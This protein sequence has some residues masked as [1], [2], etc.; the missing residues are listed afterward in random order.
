M[1]M[2]DTTMV[3]CIRCC[4]EKEQ[5]G[6]IKN[7]RA[8]SGYSTLCKECSN[9]ERRLYLD[10]RREL[11][12]EKN[13]RKYYENHEKNRKIKTERS[14]RFRQEN[15]EEYKKIQFEWRLKNPEKVRLSA[16]LS[17]KKKEFKEKRN[18]RLRENKKEVDLPKIRARKILQTAVRIGHLDRPNK[19][20]KCMK[21]CKPEAHHD[22][23]E[24]PLEVRWLCH[25]CHRHEHGKLLDVKP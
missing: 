17:S 13:R 7:K 15:P 6:F 2:E 23:Y 10:T 18:K 1:K 5:E 24:K 3:K 25:I 9:A 21:E 11:V 20:E 16:R 14:K 8:K 12:R 19:C 4:E 22:D